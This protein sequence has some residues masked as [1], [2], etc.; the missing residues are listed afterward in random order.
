MPIARSLCLAATLILASVVDA[1]DGSGLTKGEIQLPGGP[2][3]VYDYQFDRNAFAAGVDAPGGLIAL[4]RSGN[5][6]RFDPTTFKLDR[7]WFGP[8][9]ATCL[10]AG[11]AGSV[12]V[13]FEDGRVARVDPANLTQTAVADGLGKIQWVGTR[14]EGGIVAVVERRQWVDPEDERIERDKLLGEMGVGVRVLG[15]NADLLPALAW[16]PFS[17]VR[18]LT[19]GQSIPVFKLASTFAIDREDRVWLGSKENA[20]GGWVRCVDLVA[21]KP[22]PIRGKWKP[23]ERFQGRDGSTNWGFHETRDGQIWGYGGSIHETSTAD[24]NR[25]DGSRV[26]DLYECEAADG[27]GDA[28][29]KRQRPDRPNNA[30]ERITEGL[31]PDSLLVFAE[32]G[33]SAGMT[34]FRTNMKLNQW[35]KW[36]TLDVRPWLDFRDPADLMPVVREVHRRPATGD[37]ILAT[38]RDGYLRINDGRQTRNLAPGQLEAQADHNDHWHPPGNLLAGTEPGLPVAVS[39][40]KLESDSTR[41]DERRRAGSIPDHGRSGRDDG[42]GLRRFHRAPVGRQGQVDPGA[43][44]GRSDPD[45]HHARGVALAH[46]PI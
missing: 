12:L 27:F 6:L 44:A 30:I 26:E 34:I 5:L 14:R 25:L 41:P 35:S 43:T 4:T 18:D 7:E 46:L 29:K 24:I 23:S 36:L 1:A 21:G 15:D 13:G 11:P 20:Y 22:H 32:D 33:E 19:S 42:R 45:L 39:R 17:E 28:T 3:V 10:N 40:R 31:E 9:R 16:E 8:S 38:E 2:R 37:L